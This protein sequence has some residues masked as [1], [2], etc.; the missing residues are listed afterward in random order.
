MD[1]AADIAYQGWPERLYVLAKEGTIAYQ[2]GKGPY[3]FDL[4]QLHTFLGEYLSAGKVQGTPS[5]RRA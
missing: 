1:N 5:E 4:E 2:G 3:G